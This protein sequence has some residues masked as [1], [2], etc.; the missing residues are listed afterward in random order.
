MI[1]RLA[2]GILSESFLFFFGGGLGFSFCPED[3]KKESLW[4]QFLQVS[5]E[6]TTNY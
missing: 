2:E 4:S 5:T 3:T 1:L 6:L